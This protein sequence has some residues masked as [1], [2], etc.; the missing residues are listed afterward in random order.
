MMIMKSVNTWET[1]GTYR[2][3]PDARNQVHRDLFT[4]EEVSLI[5]EDVYR[6]VRQINADGG[7]Y[8]VFQ[9]SKVL[10]PARVDW[11]ALTLPIDGLTVKELLAVL[12]SAL[13]TCGFSFI[14]QLSNWEQRYWLDNLGPAGLSPAVRD[15]LDVL[16]DEARTTAAKVAQAQERQIERMKQLAASVPVSP[17]NSTFSRS[18]PSYQGSDMQETLVSVHREKAIE[19]TIQQQM[20]VAQVMRVDAEEVSHFT[21]LPDRAS[22]PPATG[23]Q[24]F[25]SNSRFPGYTGGNTGNQNQ[26]PTWV[27]YDSTGY[28]SAGQQVPAPSAEQ[29]GTTGF[30]SF[31]N[32]N[33]TFNSPPTQNGFDFTGFG[34]RRPAAAPRAPGHGSF[35]SPA[36]AVTTP[37][38][39]VAPY[40][41]HNALELFDGTGSVADAKRW[42]THY[43]YLTEC[44]RWSE[45]DKVKNMAMY[46]TGV[47]EAWFDQLPKAIKVSFKSVEAA[48]HEEYMTHHDTPM[49]RYYRLQAKR[50]ETPRQFLWR[51]NSAARAAKMDFKDARV[52]ETHIRQFLHSVRDNALQQQLLMTP[53]ATLQQ[54]EDYLK[55]REGRVRGMTLSSKP[56]RVETRASDVKETR[57]RRPSSVSRNEY[58][59]PSSPGHRPS[60]QAYYAELADTERHVRFETDFE[61]ENDSELGPDDEEL[62]AAAYQVASSRISRQPPRQPARSLA[63]SPSR[64]PQPGTG[65]FDKKDAT[66]YECG[67]KGHFASECRMRIVCGRCQSPGHP[68]ESCWKVC[69][70]CDQIHGRGECKVKSMHEEL[71]RI[72]RSPNEDTASQVASFRKLLDPTGSNN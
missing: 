41:P 45:R 46:I 59:R 31:G 36:T 27:H 66:C 47:A 40:V 7:W 50:S 60:N 21:V 51:L 32:Q 44:T 26:P 61:D 4:D 43:V 53:I 49:E 20:G 18:G 39:V 8:R 9:V 28:S 58:E 65:G 17:S 35:N 56:T 55:M 29:A 42:W 71:K 10:I 2:V 19:R 38:V 16:H 24:R 30:S 70:L 48:F 5:L 11:K 14:N 3:M 34:R 54:L 69:D 22:A 57:E 72:L 25:P 37:T 13:Y 64:V 63:H 1:A 52:L 15:I 23:A 62:E 67:N 68:A 33:S 6:F 12:Q